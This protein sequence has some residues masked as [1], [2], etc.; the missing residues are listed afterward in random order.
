KVIKENSFENILAVCTSFQSTLL[1]RK[2]GI[3]VVTL[4]DPRIDG[5][6]D[7]AIDGA[8]EFDPMLDLI[9]GGG[10]AHTQEK[11]IDGAAKDLII[12]AD[13]RKMSKRIGGK[14]PVPVEIIPAALK[15]ILIKL[16]QWEAKPELRLAVK[17]MGP[18]ITDNGN[19]IIDA[20]FG[21][22][23]DPKD[24]ETRLNNIPG[25]VENG[26][27]ANMASIIYVGKKDG[28]IEVLK[29]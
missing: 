9:K 12:V 23:D 21:V 20:N 13:E 4:D 26:I 3:P 11:I 22:I 6:L 5:K 18:V 24:L 8:D 19:F 17:K 15:P 29:K 16:K 25:V 2:Y 28:S 1:C 7:M 14:S 27:F 10:G